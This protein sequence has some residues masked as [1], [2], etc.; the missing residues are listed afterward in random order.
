M[1]DIDAVIVSF[2]RRDLLLRCCASLRTHAPDARMIVVDNASADGSA[3]A[4]AKAYPTA[5]VIPMGSNAGFA[6]ASNRGAAHG[7]APWILLLN[8]DAELTAGALPALLAALEADPGAAAAGPRIRGEDGELELSVGR[9]MSLC[10]DAMFKLL[11]SLRG[12]RLLRGLL[13]RRYRSSRAVA[14]L[15]GACMLLRRAAWEELGGMDE[16]F[17]L[18]AEDVDL[19][20]RL[21]NAGWRL[22]FVAAAEIRHLRGA[23]TGLDRATTAAH[24]WSS[25]QR[26]YSKHRTR[27]QQRLLAWWHRRRDGAGRM[28]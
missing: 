1:G 5:A 13:E 2:E 23:A 9:T 7:M 24:Y 18:Y 22:R 19:C 17:F 27:L 26:F 12:K 20:L 10:N 3:E 28:G 15:S 4:V 21:R 8:P 14:S 25:Q 16:G 11:E 6:A